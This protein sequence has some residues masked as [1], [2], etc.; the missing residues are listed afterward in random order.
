MAEES[1]DINL[2]FATDE[3]QAQCAVLP[4]LPH[5]IDL[6]LGNGFL[7]KFDVLIRPT[8]AECSW[9]SKAQKQ[10]LVIYGC[11]TIMTVHSAPHIDRNHPDE[12]A[13]QLRHHILTLDTR[14]ES[15]SG[16]EIV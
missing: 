13:E 9:Y 15:E 12:R 6:I 5:G 16:I 3:L 7:S 4:S 8:R 10:H 1:V 14:S 11:S 2:L